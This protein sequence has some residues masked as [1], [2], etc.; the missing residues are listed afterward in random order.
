MRSSCSSSFVTALPGNE[1]RYIFT[2]SVPS[3]GAPFSSFTTT[4][5]LAGSLLM[6]AAIYL[7]QSPGLRPGA[8]LGRPRA[9][10]PSRC[11]A[12]AA[13]REILLLVGL[14][15]M[16]YEDVALTLRI[17]VGTVMSRLS[18]SREKLRILMEGRATF[19]TGS[20]ANSAMRSRPA[21]TRANWRAWQALSMN[22]LRNPHEIPGTV[23]RPAF[24]ESQLRKEEARSLASVQ[25]R[26]L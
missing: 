1:S 20:T 23:C 12:P 8:R 18:R 7:Y 3:S 11:L 24:N 14:E 15:E 19:S 21:S 9:A 26:K 25:Y 5:P 13:H 17:P 6:R 2:T 16:R 10:R 4:T 22:N